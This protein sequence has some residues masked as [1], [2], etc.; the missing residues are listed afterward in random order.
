MKRV[1][2]VLVALAVLM[3]STMAMA[4][5]E[6]PWA[7][8][9]EFTGYGNGVMFGMTM[10][11]IIELQGEPDEKS[12]GMM[13]YFN[14][15]A[16]G[17]DAWVLYD[18]SSGSCKSINVF[19]SAEHT[20]DN[21]YIDDFKSIDKALTEKYGQ[22]DLDGNMIW[23]DDF[24]KGNENNYGLAISRGDLSIGSTWNFS[25]NVLIIHMIY[26]DNYEIGHAIMYNDTTDSASQTNT[27]GI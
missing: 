2:A 25:N 19:F 15:K 23:K 11:E 1:W 7:D 4:E 8:K 14:Q 24:L 12:N 6:N 16:A 27:D 3:A 9:P 5:E 22:P 17:Q 21:L 13:V 10:D 20:N 18:C 26:G